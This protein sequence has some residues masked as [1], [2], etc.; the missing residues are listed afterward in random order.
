MQLS[1][2]AVSSSKTSHPSPFPT[3]SPYEQSP[4]YSAE[5]QTPKMPLTMAQHQSSGNI[6]SS[7]KSMRLEALNP[8]LIPRHQTAT[9]SGL[10]LLLA[11][12]RMEPLS[13][14][15]REAS[16][17]GSLESSQPRG[18]PID[19]SASP[20]PVRT[21]SQTPGPGSPSPQLSEETPLL[22]HNLVPHI[23]YSSAEAGL[24][25]PPS[26]SKF[27]TKLV[28]V[29]RTACTCSGD[30]LVTCVHSLPAVLL[31]VLLNILDGVSCKFFESIL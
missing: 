7:F 17:S 26:K 1:N 11:S 20:P 25:E 18:E 3:P 22:T 15:S 23:T 27:R 24:P 29:S 19:L 6:S 14:G 8:N 21:L 16:L 12:R 31:G 30:L 4:S 9:P 28:S 13:L 5:S 2:V 10:S